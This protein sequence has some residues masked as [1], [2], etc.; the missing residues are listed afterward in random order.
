MTSCFAGP[1][2]L[3]GLAFVTI[4]PCQ[5]LVGDAGDPLVFLPTDLP[6]SRCSVWVIFLEPGLPAVWPVDGPV[7]FLV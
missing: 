4:P 2:S 7:S 3:V 1:P 5:L 6:V